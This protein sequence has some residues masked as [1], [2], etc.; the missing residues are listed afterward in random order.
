[1]TRPDTGLL[2]ALLVAMLAGAAHAGPAPDAQVL[3]DY[4]LTMAVM[5]KV[6]AA[7]AIAQ[8]SATK[9]PR[10]Q[11]LAKK[12]AEL[13]ALEAKEQP[14]DAD[15]ERMAVLADEIARADEGTA[16]NG[17]NGTT[18]ADFAKSLE[19]TPALAA[20]IKS[21]GLSSREYATAA[22]ALMQAAMIQGLIDQKMLAKAPPDVSQ[23]N[24]DFVRLN[25][26]KLEAMGVFPKGD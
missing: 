1:M 17:A 15:Q 20:A 9:D 21:A 11:A 2:V 26:A 6:A 25:R 13:A 5:E 4:K 23:Q 22:L 24:V 14:T 8:K 18:I 19:S 12:Q 3:K 7:N 10:Q 16:G